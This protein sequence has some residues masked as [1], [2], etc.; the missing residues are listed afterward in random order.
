[1]QKAID[2]ARRSLKN[3]EVPVGA[4]IVKNNRIV[5]K[6]Y[7]RIE[8]ENDATAH[9]EILAIR[10][11]GR[12]TNNWRLLDSILYVTVEPCAMCLTAIYLSRIGKVVFGCASS[13]KMYT[14]VSFKKPEIVQIP[15]KIIQE[16]CSKLMKNFFKEA[17]V[18]GN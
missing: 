16:K 4:I 15:D 1:M 2:Q 11:A 9:A 5:A 13:N 7:N 8:S 10:K 12:K 18:H 3:R 6:A 14:Y 17:R